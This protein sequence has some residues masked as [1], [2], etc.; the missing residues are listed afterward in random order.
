M[1]A[2]YAT[3]GVV[4]QKL[5]LVVVHRLMDNPFQTNCIIFGLACK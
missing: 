4:S 2:F 3:N 1:I 5:F